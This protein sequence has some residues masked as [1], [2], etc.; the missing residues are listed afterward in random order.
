MHQIHIY[1]G[2]E[3]QKNAFIIEEKRQQNKKKFI[4]FF[5]WN[6][7]DDSLVINNNWMEDEIT[8]LRLYNC[9][10][11]NKGEIFICSVA[12][13]SKRDMYIEHWCYIINTDI[14]FKQSGKKNFFEVP[15][16]TSW[17]PV[18]IFE[19]IN[20]KPIIQTI[21]DEREI[22]EPNQ[23]NL[24]ASSCGKDRILKNYQT[25]NNLKLPY[26]KY[27]DYRGRKIELVT[28]KLYIDGELKF[29]FSTIE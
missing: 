14:K 4:R 11:S 27:I 29:D 21:E 3:N 20:N 17:C 26:N 2:P 13:Y 28:Y 12:D 25:R 1:I 22:K 15:Q 8:T 5:N 9:K 19:Y 24:V 16:L 7:E 23:S 18:P 10:L 6:L